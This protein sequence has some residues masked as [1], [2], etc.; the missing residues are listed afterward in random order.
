[1][2]IL[3]YRI[4]F[5]GYAS[6]EAKSKRLIPS[7]VDEYQSRAGREWLLMLLIL[8]MSVLG[9][10]RLIANIDALIR[11]HPAL[12][13]QIG[14]AHDGALGP[15]LIA[16]IAFFCAVSFA[17]P[18]VWIKR[19]YNRTLH[20]ELTTKLRAKALQAGYIAAI[21][22]FAGAFVSLAVTT[23]NPLQLILWLMFAGVALPILYFMWLEW[24]ANRSG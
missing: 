20:D 18:I 2:A 13:G 1:V 6:A 10:N 12:A 17:I 21:G 16:G 23:V 24:R 3:I 14:I 15:V 22:M 4:V 7:Q 8:L 5:V 19:A 9:E 11:Q